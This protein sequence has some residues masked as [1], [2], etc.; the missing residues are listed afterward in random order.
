MATYHQNGQ[1]Q[2]RE[3]ILAQL[4]EPMVIGQTYYCSFRVN[5]AFGGNHIY[6]Q[7]WLAND[8]VGMRFT[9]TP[10][11]LGT[12]VIPSRCRPTMRTS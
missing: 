5:A 8:K 11:P 2:Q 4:L 3:W 9:T 6:P 1:D 10:M 7:H 12:W